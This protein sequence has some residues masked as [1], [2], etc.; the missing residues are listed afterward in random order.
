MF[1]ACTQLSTIYVSDLWNISAS[2]TNSDMF[3]K[4]TSLVGAAPFD[5][6]KT[7]ASMA[8]YET[9]Y[10]TYKRYVKPEDMLI[11]NTTL[12]NIAD[13]I[14]ILTG[15][16]NTMTPSEMI[17]T[18]DNVELGVDTSDATAT[19]D[20]VAAGATYYAGGVKVV[21][22]GNFRKVE[23]VQ[24]IALTASTSLTLSTWDHVNTT[25]VEVID[26]WGN[27]SY[28]A[29]PNNL[30][31]WAD[32]P[33]MKSAGDGSSKVRVAI[34]AM[35]QSTPKPLIIQMQSSSYYLSTYLQSVRLV[36]IT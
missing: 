13:K 11:K 36:K 28:V 26:K 10:F 29:D 9:G 1:F 19:P 3:Y 32:V 5:S 34:S 22:T 25:H 24:D 35:A 27:I 17:A 16:T 30:N 21:G 12:Y 15:T 14:R 6:T 23:V 8:N 4:C 33:A 7:D 18:L 20:Q 31:S 2:T